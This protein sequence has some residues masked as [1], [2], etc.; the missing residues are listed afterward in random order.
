MGNTIIDSLIVKLGLDS[1][2]FK[3]GTAEADKATDTFT[4]KTKKQ[5]KEQAEL[6]RKSRKEQKE[7][8]KDVKKGNDSAFDS[9]EKLGRKYLGFYAIAKAGQAV[10]RETMATIVKGSELG[11]LSDNVNI[12]ANSLNA[13]GI[14]AEKAGGNAQGM[15][16]QVGLAAKQVAQAQF[17]QLDQTGLNFLLWGGS[18]QGGEFKDPESLLKAKIKLIQDLLVKFKGDRVK[19]AYAASQFGADQNF[20]DLALKPEDFNKRLAEAKAQSAITT[21][22][23]SL[24]KQTEASIAGIKAHVEAIVTPLQSVVGFAADV[25]EKATGAIA[26]DIKEGFVNDKGVQ[27]VKKVIKFIGDEWKK[28]GEA[29]GAKEGLSPGLVTAVVGQES[30]GKP[31]ATSTKGAYGRMQLMPNTAKE[32]AAHFGEVYDPNDEDQNLR[33]GAYYLGKQKKAFGGD[34]LK[35]LAAYNAGPERTRE[36]LKRGRLPAETQKYIPK[37]MANMPG[38]DTGVPEKGRLRASLMDYIPKGTTNMPGGTAGQTAVVVN[39]NI[40]LQGV[41]NP[42]ELAK[43]LGQTFG[44]NT[45]TVVNATSGQTR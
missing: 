14:A 21:E 31:E 28:S 24:A 23:T 5:S 1:S 37:V 19:V 36:S 27:A 25:A 17:G 22:T 11:Y 7:R 43:K 12:S 20:V 44:K 35:A 16:A 3:K 9:L 26:K 13:W 32:I 38:A 8:A 18:D 10:Y 6:D 42:P 41:N 40:V 2:E 30:K 15:M 45:A 33:F 34:E 39:G 4:K 29:Y